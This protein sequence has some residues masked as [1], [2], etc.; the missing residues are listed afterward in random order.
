[1]SDSK[2]L[3]IAS[4]PV[5][6]VGLTQLEEVRVALERSTS[7]SNVGLS[8]LDPRIQAW[9]H[10]CLQLGTSEQLIDSLKLFAQ[11]APVV[12]IE[13]SVSPSDQWLETLVTWLRNQIS[14]VLLVRLHVRRNI[15]A[16]FKIR[17]GRHEYDMSLATRFNQV[18]KI[19][20]IIH[21]G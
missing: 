10:D 9:L 18:K 3:Q 20:E 1:M 4:L 17:T 2:T 19:P 11:T 6:L 14:P 5:S 8:A 16:G 13:L 7:E 12:D 21:A 15:I